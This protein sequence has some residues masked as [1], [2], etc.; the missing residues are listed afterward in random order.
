MQH[1]L[2]GT[3]RQGPKRRL[4]KLETPSPPPPSHVGGTGSKRQFRHHPPRQHPS[5]LQSEAIKTP[6]PLLC[7]HSTFATWLAFHPDGHQELPV[8]SQPDSL[9][10]PELSKFTQNPTHLQQLIHAGWPSNM[11]SRR[12]YFSV[13]T[14]HLQVRSAHG[15][16]HTHTHHR[17]ENSPGGERNLTVPSILSLP[18]LWRWRRDALRKTETEA[19]TEIGG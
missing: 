11:R 10:L 9:L 14:L 8:A 3:S 6:P 4:T 7:S 1:T 19:H 5:S 18:D 16:N 2:V 17:R 15:G 12:L 13:L